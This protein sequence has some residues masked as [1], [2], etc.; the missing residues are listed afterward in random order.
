MRLQ[1]SRQRTPRRGFTLVELMMVV[2]IIGMLL[3]IAVPNFV[4]AREGSRAKACQHNLLQI[5]SAKERWAMDKNRQATDTPG[6]PELAVPG[7]YMRG[8][9]ECPGGGSYTVGRL[10]QIPTC[11]I[12]GVA[13]DQEAHVL[14]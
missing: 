7:V 12:G 1:S 14:P 4:H 13:G 6:M 3:S 10:N 5:Q 11:S 8:N 2:M 9:P